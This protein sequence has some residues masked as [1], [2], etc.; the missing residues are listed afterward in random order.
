MLNILTKNGTPSRSSRKDRV[1]LGTISDL[2]GFYKLRVYSDCS[3][4]L[5]FGKKVQ[6]VFFLKD[7]GTLLSDLLKDRKL[8]SLHKIRR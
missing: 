1:H 5:T 3:N 6:K 8:N 4:F 2:V 7:G